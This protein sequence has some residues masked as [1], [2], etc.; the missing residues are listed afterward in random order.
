MTD[1]VPQFTDVD[2]DLNAPGGVMDKP[3]PP[4]V[5]SPRTESQT[6]M[7]RAE[8][9]RTFLST[10]DL[11]V[12][13]VTI[14]LA[15]IGCLMV[16]ST[17]F[18]WSFSDYGSDTV[19]FMQHVRNLGIGL[20]VLI[21]LFVIDYRIWKRFAVPILLV[22]IGSLIAVLLF[23][24]GK[25]GAQRS[26]F[27]GSYQPGEMAELTIVIYMA[28]WLSSKRTK[29]RSITF[30]LLPFAILLGII[31]TLVLL[32]PD[33]STAATIA[34]TAGLMF[35]LAGANVTHLL[36]ALTLMGVSGWVIS[37]RLSYAQDRVSTY[38]AGLTDLTQTNYHAQQAIIA[39]Q[40]GGWTGVGLGQGRQK[41]PGLLP[42]PHTDSIFAIIGEE[43]GVLG[44]MFVIL[45]FVLLVIRGL[46][47]ASHARDAFGSLLAAGVTLW[48]IT[49]AWMNIAV[50]LNLLPS[51]G[52]ALPL[53]SFGGSSLVTVM[54]GVGL[55]LSVARFSALHHTP[56]G[57]NKSARYDRGWGNRWSRVSSLSRNGSAARPSRGR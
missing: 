44:A 4:I 8:R 54:A 43:L 52:V 9:R 40:N 39:F 24:D 37:Q 21:P 14:L 25:W 33:L 16:Y 46:R 48:I 11:P 30:G 31:G 5:R 27:N 2:F 19:I 7:M 57:R 35:Y 55:L 13:V 38:I 45:L 15:A 32:Q 41:F 22:T 56:E 3:Y 18:D 47:I 1:H 53:I 20:A 28:A 26:F 42:T 12:T 49:K 29:V 51:T 10:L 34:V 36:A 23:G 6:G 50:M 17:T